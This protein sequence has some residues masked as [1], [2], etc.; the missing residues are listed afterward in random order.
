MLLFP[1]V[2]G[3]ASVMWILG[4][5]FVPVP[6]LLLVVIVVMNW[7]LKRERLSIG[8]KR[9]RWKD[10]VYGSRFSARLDEV[11]VEKC[12]A[13][14]EVALMLAGPRSAHPLAIG[15]AEDIDAFALEID[16]ALRRAHS[17]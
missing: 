16:A 7:P 11:R 1:L 3:I 14:G 9:V 12:P 4:F 17:V 2:F 10:R 13:R 8:P 5:T 6:G 15:A